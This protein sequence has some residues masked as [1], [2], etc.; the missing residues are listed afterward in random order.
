MPAD[1]VGLS[2]EVQQLADPNFFSPH[3]TG[4]IREFKALSTNGVLRL[5]G[6]TSEFAYW[7]PAL[8]SPEPEHPKTREVIGEPK[9]GVLRSHRRSRAQP[10][11]LPQFNRLDLPL[12]HRH[13]N[14]HAPARRGRSRVCRHHSRDRPAVFPDRQRSRPVRPPSARPSNLVFEDVSRRVAH[15]CP[16]DYRPRAPGAIRHARCGLKGRVAY[17]DRRPLAFRPES[18]PRHHSDPSSLLRRPGHKPRSQYSQPAQAG[19]HGKGAEDLRHRNRR[20]RQK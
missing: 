5:G 1:F 3:N 19:H 9:T 10:R 18:T 20:R 17:R 2:Y 11:G 13:G 15:H 16:G 8:S 14:Q 6:N 7:R 12:R 4:L